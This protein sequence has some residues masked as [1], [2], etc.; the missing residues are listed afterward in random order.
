MTISDD[1]SDAIGIGKYVSDTFA[2]P[3]I[4]DWT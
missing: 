1:E 4:M 2:K 3:K